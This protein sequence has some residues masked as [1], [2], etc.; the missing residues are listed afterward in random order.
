MWMDV[1]TIF[2]CNAYLLSQQ[3]FLHSVGIRSCNMQPTKLWLK[4]VEVICSAFSDRIPSN[5][6]QDHD[7]GGKQCKITLLKHLS[8]ARSIKTPL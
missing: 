4:V 6:V 5:L 2:T 3:Y 1:T 8:Q 7:N